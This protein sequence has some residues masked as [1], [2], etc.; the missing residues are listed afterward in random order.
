M[1][2]EIFSVGDIYHIRKKTAVEI[3][4]SVVLSRYVAYICTAAISTSGI[5]CGL[6]FTND[7][8]AWAKG[9]GCNG[10][11]ISEIDEIVT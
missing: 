1:F 4:I 9:N 8:V 7:H 11:N 5:L 10:G 6:F 3:M 2:Q